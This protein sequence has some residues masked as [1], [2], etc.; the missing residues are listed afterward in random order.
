MKSDLYSAVLSQDMSYFDNTSSWELRELV[1]SCGSVL[2]RTHPPALPCGAGL[3]R[4]VEHSIVDGRSTHAHYMLGAVALHKVS[5]C[6]LVLDQLSCGDR[7]PKL[8]LLSGL[9][10]TAQQGLLSLLDRLEDW[11]QVSE[12]SATHQLGL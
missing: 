8:T 3:P 6:D 4:A 1:D 9:L 5:C 7:S 2:F 12:Y 10:L 11:I